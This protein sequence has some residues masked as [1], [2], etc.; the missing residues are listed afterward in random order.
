VTVNSYCYGTYI[1]YNN[2]DILV[3]TIIILHF[4]YI[5]SL[6]NY[7]AAICGVAVYFS[8]S[9]LVSMNV[10]AQRRARLVLGW[11]TAY[12]RVSLK[13]V[14]VTSHR[15]QLSYSSIQSFL[16]IHNVVY[17]GVVQAQLRSAT[18]P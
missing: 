1:I 10:V 3:I 14:T 5:L 8:V 18:T 13:Y 15:A 12:R 2:I 11:V 7:I 16:C 4:C 6:Y 9:A 17:L